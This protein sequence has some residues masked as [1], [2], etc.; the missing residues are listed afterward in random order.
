MSDVELRRA[1]S[2]RFL[3]CI[4]GA[5]AA[6]IAVSCSVQPLKYQVFGTFGD[7][8][9]YKSLEVEI[10]GPSR[11]EQKMVDETIRTTL[12]E[13]DAG[14]EC[15]QECINSLLK[16]LPLQDTKS[17]VAGYKSC[18]EGCGGQVRVENGTKWVGR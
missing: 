1:R 5:V 8:N 12:P 10:K 17:C 4:S 6:T 18:A 3:L 15:V 9:K 7:N 13:A 11:G 2:C 14:R 16:N